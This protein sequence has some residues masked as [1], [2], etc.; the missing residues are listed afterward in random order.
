M[1]P[2]AREAR[3]YRRRFGGSSSGG[4]DSLALQVG[5]ESGLGTGGPFVLDVALR[6]DNSP[7]ATCGNTAESSVP[8]ASAWRGVVR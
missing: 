6:K 1:T 5:R 4:A 7:L 8:E 2:I 3:S